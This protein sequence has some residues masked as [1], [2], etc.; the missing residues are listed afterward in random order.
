MAIEIDG[1][2]RIHVVITISFPGMQLEQR[3]DTYP[4]T[5]VPSVDSSNLWWHLFEHAVAEGDGKLSPPE[6]YLGAIDARFVRAAGI[7]AFGF[8]PIRPY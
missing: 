5:L 7:P 4:Q 3:G 1:V 8:L 6:I 2:L